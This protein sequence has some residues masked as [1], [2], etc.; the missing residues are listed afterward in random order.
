MERKLRILWFSNTPAASDETVGSS[1]TG[2]WLKSLDKAIQDKVELHVAFYD[3]KKNV[4]FEVGRTKYY[5]FSSPGFKGFIRRFRAYWG[6]ESQFVDR[7]NQI[8]EIVNPD[9]IH[10]HGTELG[11]VSVVKQTKVPV[12]L[13]IQAILQSMVY[14]YFGDFKPKDLGTFYWWS[15]Y[16]KDYRFF[17]RMARIERECVP[18]LDFVIGRTDW[19]RR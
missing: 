11:F 14:K 18:Y 4:D 9:I 2:G 12:I 17:K 10:I 5:T 16:Y 15:Q 1:G 6:G 8:L 3:K 7:W 19:D 13:S